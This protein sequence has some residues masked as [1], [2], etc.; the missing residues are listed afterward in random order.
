MFPFLLACVNCPPGVEPNESG[1][2]V[3]S[4]DD[5]PVDGDGTINWDDL[6]ASIPACEP[7]SAGTEIDFYG[8]CVDEVCVGMG[9]DEVEAAWGD[10][11][12]DSTECEYAS[13]VTVWYSDDEVYQLELDEPYAGSDSVGLGIGAGIGCFVDAFD[14]PDALDAFVEN[15]VVSIWGLGWYDMNLTV[16][17]GDAFGSDRGDWIVDSIYLEGV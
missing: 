12:C 15:G 2:C 16:F 9:L 8:G 11:S 3:G 14:T 10:G 13:G 1:E 17:D 6:A 7:L 5:S 4:A